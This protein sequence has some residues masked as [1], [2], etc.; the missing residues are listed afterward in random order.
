VAQALVVVLLYNVRLHQWWRS[1]FPVYN[2]I[3]GIYCDTA[4]FSEH[5]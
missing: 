4:L 5:I 2:C 1:R 3:F